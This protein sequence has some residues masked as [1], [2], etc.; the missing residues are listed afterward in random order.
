MSTRQKLLVIIFT[1]VLFLVNCE[2]GKPKQTTTT[3]KTAI[4]KVKAPVTKKIVET[5][6]DS[7]LQKRN[8]IYYK[9]DAEIP[10]TGRAVGYYPNGQKYLVEN[11]KDGK[12]HGKSIWRDKNEQIQIFRIASNTKKQKKTRIAA[13]KKLNG[14]TFIAKAVKKDYIEGRPRVYAEGIIRLCELM[15]HDKK[16]RSISQK[17]VF[18]MLEKTYGGSG[19]FQISPSKD[20]NASKLVVKLKNKKILQFFQKKRTSLYCSQ[21]ANLKLF[22]LNSP[23]LKK[24]YGELNLYFVLNRIKN[25]KEYWRYGDGS[26]GNEYNDEIKIILRDPK[27]KLIYSKIFRDSHSS[28][29]TKSNDRIGIARIKLDAIH[30]DLLRKL[31]DQEVI[32]GIAKNDPD[33]IARIIAVSKLLDQGLLAEIVRKK[34]YQSVIEA[35]LNKLKDQDLLAAIATNDKTGWIRLGATRKLKDQKLIAEIAKNDEME[36][37]R[38]AAKKRLKK[39][40]KKN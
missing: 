18:K 32:A 21:L 22:L 33:R 19:T 17:I 3:I 6:D 11:Y 39:L 12:K 8:G 28:I 34:E 37:I 29:P 14:P 15:R 30:Y 4:T 31:K 10:F 5:I 24:T 23:F 7:K 35:A 38:I 40:R 9:K 1:C 27:L 20:L 2:D 16:K 26:T 25:E 13:I 36:H